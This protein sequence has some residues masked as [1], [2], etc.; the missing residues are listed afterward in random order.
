MEVTGRKARNNREQVTNMSESIE[1]HENAA[2]K[3]ETPIFQE[4]P[5][6]F[7]SSAYALTD[8]DSLHA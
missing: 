7:E 6:S 3:W 5:I 2:K 4:I 1:N 8:E